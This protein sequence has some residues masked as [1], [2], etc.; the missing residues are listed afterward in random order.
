M[1]LKKG[2]T[3][4]LVRIESDDYS[5]YNTYFIVNQ[6]GVFYAVDDVYCA[7]CQKTGV[8]KDLTE[9]RIERENKFGTHLT[10]YMCDECK[11]L[12]P[13]K[14]TKRKKENTNVKD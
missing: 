12:Y 10:G 1:K 7:A 11:K 13:H 14:K 6:D 9:Y 8:I 2:D 5:D 3:F 4:T